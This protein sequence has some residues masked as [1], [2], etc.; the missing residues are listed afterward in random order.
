[1][2]APVKYETI[3]LS[4]SSEKTEPKIKDPRSI[5]DLGHIGKVI[6]D[7]HWDTDSTRFCLEP[8][9]YSKE[10]EEHAEIIKKAEF[11]D[12]VDALQEMLKSG[13]TIVT[14]SKNDTIVGTV[15]AVPAA[16]G[17]N[18][19]NIT[20]DLKDPVAPKKA[21]G[22]TNEAWEERVK[23]WGRNEYRTRCFK[24]AVHEG[25]KAHHEECPGTLW[26]ITGLAV[27]K[28]HEGEGTGKA[29]AKRAVEAVPH[30]N[31]IRL[32]RE[33]GKEGIWERIGFKQWSN[34]EHKTIKLEFPQEF[35]RWSE[36][37]GNTIGPEAPQQDL[38]MKD[39][40]SNKPWKVVEQPILVKKVEYPTHSEAEI[41]V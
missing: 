3:N 7:V 18:H 30:G 32:I 40:D 38:N 15:V 21:E 22:E 37:E 8:W 24:R 6:A 39:S 1:M 35:K 10:V 11:D 31:T 4:E 36:V 5:P 20:N 14:A 25:L 26:E 12:W 41:S 29:L 17:K 2:S 27:L 28:G 13:G 16:K 34:A 23:D 9:V 19:D 33:G